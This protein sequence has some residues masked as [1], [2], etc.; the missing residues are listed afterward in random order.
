MKNETFEVYFWSVFRY[1]R[2]RFSASKFGILF[3]GHR[4]SGTNIFTRKIYLRNLVTWR[5]RF[6]KLFD[7][8]EFEKISDQADHFPMVDTIFIS[9]AIMA[10]KWLQIQW[11]RK[12][13]QTWNHT[14][15]FKIFINKKT[16]EVIHFPAASSSPPA[17][18]NFIE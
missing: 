8:L 6:Y 3:I 18:W 15:F 13:P 14:I 12:I 5:H 17:E 4:V 9:L 2:N 16:L 1:F 11:H 7:N 10:W